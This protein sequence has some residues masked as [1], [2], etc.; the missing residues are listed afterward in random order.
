MSEFDTS[1][2]LTARTGFGAVASLLDQMRPRYELFTD[3][4]LES[5]ATGSTFTEL[6]SNNI[7]GVEADDLIVVHST[8]NLSGDANDMRIRVELRAG[9][10]ASPE[11]YYSTNANST[12]G[13]RGPVS[14]LHITTGLSGTVAIASW[15]EIQAIGSGTTIYS[16]REHTH[17]LLFKNGGTIL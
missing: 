5:L 2:L 16:D 12:L 14:I 13:R 7:T 1:A 4:T 6:R 8:I 15:W 3:G 9:A 10:N 17:V 11:T